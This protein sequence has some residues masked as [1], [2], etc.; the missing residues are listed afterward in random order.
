M[1]YHAVIRFPNVKEFWSNQE[2][3]DLL[4]TI[5]VPYINKQ[6]RLVNRSYGTVVLN[7]GAANLLSV[8]RTSNELQDDFEKV[9]E[10]SLW[11]DGQFKEND[12]TAQIVEEALS[13]RWAVRA[14]SPIEKAL[15]ITKRQVL[16]IM[17]FGDKVLDS[18]YAG[19]IVPT[20]RK[21]KY[22]PLRID[23][24]QDGGNVTEEMLWEIATSQIV[25][26]DLTGERPNCYY[27]A[28]FAHAMAKDIVFTIQTGSKMHF[29]LAGYRFIWW[30][31]EDELRTKLRERFKAI[32]LRASDG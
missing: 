25:L 3:D 27:E 29:D 24:I 31:T 21:F 23:E 18:A 17:K 10:K 4:R 5:V 11:S 26:A 32:S 19:V 20:V 8:F 16:V 9:W 14:R 1:Y 13:M 15:G 12:C 7:F 6:V 28:G 2:Y 30:A 22:R